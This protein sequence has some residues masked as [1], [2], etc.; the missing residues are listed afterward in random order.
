MKLRTQTAPFLPSESKKTWQRSCL[1][2]SFVHCRV[3]KKKETEEIQQFPGDFFPLGLL[4]CAEVHHSHPGGK[5]PSTERKK[6]LL[7]CPSF[8]QPSKFVLQSCL[9][10][11]CDY[12]WKLW[13]FKSGGKWALEK[14]FT[15]FWVSHTQKAVPSILERRPGSDTVAIDK[16]NSREKNES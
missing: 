16:C 15:V 12:G 13:Q 2:Q 6:S 3:K 5:S 1:E 4:C 9:P 10:A 14:S 8:P 7:L 11:L